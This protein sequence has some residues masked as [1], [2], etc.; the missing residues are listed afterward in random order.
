MSLTTYG[1]NESVIEALKIPICPL[2]YYGDET[3]YDYFNNKFGFKRG[4]ISAVR[5]NK[6]S[7]MVAG[8]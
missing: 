1:Y 2:H 4:D 5:A 7:P 3:K 6:T 8:A